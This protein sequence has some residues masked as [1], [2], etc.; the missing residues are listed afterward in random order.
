MKVY[1]LSETQGMGDLL[2]GVFSTY[3]KAADRQKQLQ[4]DK[5]SMLWIGEVEVDWEPPKPLEAS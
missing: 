1:T 4:G 3:Q 2:L 5:P